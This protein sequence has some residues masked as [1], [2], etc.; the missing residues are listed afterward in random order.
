MAAFGL[1]TDPAGNFARERS[2]HNSLKGRE[3][4]RDLLRSP[5]PIGDFS[6]HFK[7]T[8]VTQVGGQRRP[9][10]PSS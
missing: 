9:L 5:L 1:D 6:A 10:F 4:N 3:Q 7:F 8:A 2:E